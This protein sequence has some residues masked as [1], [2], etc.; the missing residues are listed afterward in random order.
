VRVVVD[1]NVL[2]SGLLWRGAPHQ[3][4]EQ[5]KLE[6]FTILSSPLLLAEFEQVIRRQNF[7]SMLARSRIDLRRLLRDV[8]QL[9]EIVGAPPLR[10][11]ASRDPDD[12]Q[13]LAPAF[14]AK[15]DLIVSGD[16]DLLSL[17]QHTGIRIVSPAEALRL[18]ASRA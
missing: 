4:I 7:R 16:D 12:D 15:A 18:I 11:R 14:A 13:V 1:T 5:A 2:I 9:V 8:A 10:Q 3:L 6:V 17:R